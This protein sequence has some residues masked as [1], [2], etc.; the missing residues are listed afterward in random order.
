MQRLFQTLGESMAEFTAFMY[1]QYVT[2]IETMHS[3]KDQEEYTKLVEDYQFA[4]LHASVRISPPER[5]QRQ[6]TITRPVP[7]IPRPV[8]HPPQL[9]H[10]RP[11]PPIPPRPRISLRVDT[12]FEL[13]VSIQTEETDAHVEV[14]SR[15][16][17]HEPVIPPEE[18]EDECAIC[19]E[20]IFST[21][22]SPVQTTCGHLFHFGCI[23][24]WFSQKGRY[25]CPMCRRD[26]CVQM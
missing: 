1:Q 20:A 17:T 21:G 15:R 7:P 13:A 26:P 12:D 4:Y 25:T 5:P 9:T 22:D 24:T 11:P 3:E 6:F 14:Y 8:P 2:T 19:K 18:K 16:T 10:N 23:D